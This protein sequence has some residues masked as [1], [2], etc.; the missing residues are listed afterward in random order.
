ME[1]RWRIGKEKMY[2]GE[3]KIKGTWDNKK[4]IKTSFK[5]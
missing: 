1:R 5:K 3:G 2:I 4:N